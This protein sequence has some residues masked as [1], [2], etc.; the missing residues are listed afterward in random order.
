MEHGLGKEQDMSVNSLARCL[1]FFSK[2]SEYKTCQ[3]LVDN[4]LDP[5]DGER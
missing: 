2:E 5:N 3:V 1:V 4:W